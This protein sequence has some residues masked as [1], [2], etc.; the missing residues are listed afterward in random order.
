MSVFKI[1]E[2][3]YMKI[4]FTSRV[5]IYTPASKTWHIIAHQYAEVGA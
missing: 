5:T 4:Q 1:A 2:D 3:R